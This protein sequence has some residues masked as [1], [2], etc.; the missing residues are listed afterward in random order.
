M[1][2]NQHSAPGSNAGFS[3]QF[4]R[5]LFWLAQSPAGF[6]VGVETDDD[7]AVRGTDGSQLLEQDK[8]SIRDNVKPFGD[9]SK[10]L[11]NTLAIWIEALNTG[12]VAAETV[13][14]LMVTNKVLPDC[15]ARKISLAETEEQVTAC[16]ALLELEA[17]T[18]PN[19]I[20]AYIQR[21]LNPDSRANL[22][23]LI[24]RCELADA[25]DDSA[26]KL[27]RQKTISQLQL[28]DWCSADSD[29]ITDELLG[30][31]HRT[32]LNSWQQNI[33]AWIKRD[34]FVN[35]LHAVIDRRKRQ[36]KRERAENLIPVTDD[37]IGQQKGSPFVKQ[38]Y[39][40]TDDD[41][42]VDNAIR[43][44]IRCNI[45]KMRLS[46]EGNITDDD[47]IAFETTLKSRWDKIRS[48]IIR[49]SHGNPEEDVGFEI[50]TD[51]T[52]DH[53]EKLAGSDTDQVYL[54]SGT[55]HRLANMIQV[56][57]HPRF[58]E[59]MREIQEMS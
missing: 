53:R 12:E 15:I 21:V 13:R 52:E 55:Y 40:V 27:L 32:A 28:P 30:W 7:V 17:K 35:Q 46:A 24:E 41:S 43:E 34:S 42:V 25:I 2:L 16:I 37:N 10:D 9:R 3:Y 38:I 54:T 14:F 59:L 22:K 31:L 56:G 20:A 50:F 33:P 48:R 44:F 36:I 45:E 5:A 23:K 18:P 57:W 19:H 6:V 11:W 1:T 58:E 51:T 29:S 47:W 8:H 4:E 26:G 49:M 39:L